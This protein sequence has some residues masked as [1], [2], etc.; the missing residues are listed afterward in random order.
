MIVIGLTGSI[1]MG[2]SETANMFRAEGVRV[3]DAD[4]EA[5]QLMAKGGDAVDAIGALFPG[6]V[7]DG[8]VDRMAL[9]KMVFGE[10]EAL[11]KLE[12]ILHPKIGEAR[13]RFLEKA[14]ADGHSLVV[15]DVPL[16]FEKGHKDKVDV[17]V[18]VSCPAEE[19][20]ARVM[21]RA[22]MTAEKLD[23]ILSLQTPDHEKRAKADYIIETDKGLDHARQSV[24]GLIKKLKETA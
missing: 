11:L 15:L 19:Q 8:A 6:A 10:E 22:G 12:A 13:A 9:G 20:K 1:G 4:A 17:I 18:V 16:L 24:R 5:H 2:K 21:A 14:K 3:F 23:A 7:K